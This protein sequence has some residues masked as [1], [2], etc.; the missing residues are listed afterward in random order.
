MDDGGAHLAFDIVADQRHPALTK[1]FAPLRILG[2]E[3]RNTVNKTATGAQRLLG[4]PPGGSLRTDRQ[5]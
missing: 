4:I 5:I 2:D 3:H 1:P